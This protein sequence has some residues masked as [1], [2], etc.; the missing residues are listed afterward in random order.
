[1]KYSAYQD[2]A[3]EYNSR[4]SEGLGADLTMIEPVITFLDSNGARLFESERPARV[5]TLAR[6]GAEDSDAK[7]SFYSREPLPPVAVGDLL[8][9]R[10]DG[11][12]KFRGSVS[13][14]RT[15]SLRFPLVVRAARRPTRLYQ[16][17]IRKEYTDASPTEILSDVLTLVLGET[18]S[19]S[20][21]P[22]S[23]RTI[24]RLDFRGTPLFYAVDLLARLAGN[25]LWWI[26]WEGELHFIPPESAPEH[27]WYY[28]SE[29]MALHPWLVDKPIK[30]R[31]VLF[32]GVSGG[33]EFT[34]FFEDAASADRYGP[35]EERLYARPI[36][37]DLVYT[38]LRDAVLEESPEPANYRA[39]DRFDGD[40][41][42]S[43]G[44][45]FELRANPL[46]ELDEDNVYRIAA[47]ELVWTPGS[48][49]ARY[50][51]AAG[52][53]SA[54]RYT[55]YIDHDPEGTFFVAARLGSFQLDFSALDSE[56]HLD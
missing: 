47:E 33:E 32:G 28:E 54:S 27:V 38:Y 41:A 3:R 4:A 29:R 11:T 34:K 15:D 10:F 25:W 44:E 6:F 5:E 8:E 52:L 18:P 55:R 14:L 46:R 17:E 1:M 56:A 45:R 7:V 22:A 49:L 31:F 42:A 40:L 30:N 12:L 39:V 19:Y 16:S 23:T 43:F 26:D 13:E 51:L 2:S 21:A 36:T 35:V 20:G 50:H 48:F 24:D 53:E 9:V 37:T